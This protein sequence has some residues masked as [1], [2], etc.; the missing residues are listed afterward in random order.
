MKWMAVLLLSA[1][2]L[3]AQGLV[4]DL[5]RDASDAVRQ[6]DASKAEFL[7]RQMRLEAPKDERWA[8]GLLG[9]LMEQDRYQDA[10]KLAREVGAQF[11]KSPVIHLQAGSVLLKSGRPDE[12]LKEFESGVQYADGP[13][14][15]STGYLLMGSAYRDLNELDDSIVAFRKAKAITGRANAAYAIVLGERGKHEEE[16]AEYQA[17]LRE[18]PDLPV[19]LNNLAYIWA[20]RGEHLGEAFSMAQRAVAA[21][22]GDS[23]MVDTLAWV[24]FRM[25]RLADAESTMLDALVRE[26]GNHPTLREHLAEVMDARGDWSGD[27]RELRKLMDGE[28]SAGQLARMKELLRKF[29]GEK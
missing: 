24:Y 16:I 14:T 4:D 6:G 28:L 15:E 7:F 18:T 3:L 17:V 21:E 12:A 27:R 1:P 20:E 8:T 26:G 29:Q 13:G 11:P 19:A 23:N 5:Y 22:P 9:V 2:G 25:G 10:M